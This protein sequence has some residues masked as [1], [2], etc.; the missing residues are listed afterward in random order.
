MTKMLGVACICV[1]AGIILMMFLPTKIWGGL[2]AVGLLL[3][4]IRLFLQGRRCR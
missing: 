4:G 3:V 1:A 2:F